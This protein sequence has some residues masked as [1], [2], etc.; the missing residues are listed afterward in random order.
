MTW[1]RDALN[2]VE[3]P[4]TPL[5]EPRP[6]WPSAGSAVYVR[7]HA[8][9][10]W[11]RVGTTVSPTGRLRDQN[12]G[13]PRLRSEMTLTAT[14]PAF[15]ATLSEIAASP[16]ETPTTE[17]PY[18]LTKAMLRE[19]G[20]CGPYVRKFNETFPEDRYPDG[21][22]ITEESC[23][24]H[25]ET[26][27]WNWALQVMLTYDGRVLH[28]KLMRSRAT[29]NKRFG[30]GEQRRAAIFGHIFDTLPRH[31]HENT[32]DLTTRAEE[33][34][35][36]DALA[37]VETVRR[38]IQVAEET[39]A[40]ATRDLERF[41]TQLGPLEDRASGA[42]LRRARRKHREAQQAVTRLR[43]RVERAEEAVRTTGAEV[44]RLEAA[45]TASHDAPV[46]AESS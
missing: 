38:G 3:L 43:A 44:A 2:R 26:F 18:R 25:W 24:Q 21:V 8:T 10:R 41:R 33:R 35:D 14:L 5:P 4:E 1:R 36:R 31:R 13:S 27:D 32:Q 37:Q 28:D 17:A 30:T 12:D 7:P 19:L 11:V 20:S 22:D 42:Q 34:D 15:T 46:R 16:L 29:H 45:A 23:A 9:G 39:I 6:W 40:R